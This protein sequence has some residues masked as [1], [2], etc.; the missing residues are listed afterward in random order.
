[1]S[2]IHVFLPIF[3]SQPLSRI[4]VFAR[5]I[6]ILMC[7]TPD[8]CNESFDHGIDHPVFFLK[9]DCTEIN[10]LSVGIVNASAACNHGGAMQ[11]P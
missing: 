1:M 2:K 8:M 11:V 4:R 3:Q 10:P 5:L 9:S 7:D 6:P